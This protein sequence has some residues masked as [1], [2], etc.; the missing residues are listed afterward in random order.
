MLVDLVPVATRGVR[1]PDLDQRARHRPPVVVEHAAADDDALAER[2]ALV[3]LRQ[4]VVELAERVFAEDGAVERVELLG[5]RDERPLRRAQSA[6]SGSRGSRAGRPGR[7]P[8]RPGR[9]I[10]V[11]GHAA[12]ERTQRRQLVRRR[13]PRDAHVVGDAQRPAGRRHAPRRPSTPGCT[14]RE[15][16]L[17]VA[18]LEHAEVGDDDAHARRRGSS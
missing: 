2:L 1:L 9:T 17:A 7:S 12:S 16:E 15:R 14:R 13:R 5:Q 3:L 11:V 10:A 18:R 4:V 8:G 6:S